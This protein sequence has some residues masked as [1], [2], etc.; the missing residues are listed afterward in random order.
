[1][2]RADPAPLGSFHLLLKTAHSLPVPTAGAGEKETVRGGGLSPS[3]RLSHSAV[4]EHTHVCMHTE[5]Q[6]TPEFSE[7]FEKA[8]G[9]N[10]TGF[11]LLLACVK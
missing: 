5:T 10:E 4:F 11:N 6:I 2:P 8:F 1:M 9:N 3:L 7:F